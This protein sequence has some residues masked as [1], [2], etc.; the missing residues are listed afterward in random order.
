MTTLDLNFIRSQFPAFSEPSL[1]G[2][3]FFNNAGGSY[4]CKPVIDRLTQFYRET[5]VQP[6]GFSPASKI[7]G[8]KMD[9]SYTR[10]AAYLNVGEDEVLFGPSTSQ[11]T[12]VLA[13]AFREAWSPGDEI[14][15][16]NQDHEANSGVWRKLAGEGIVVR[17]WTID[18]ETGVLN[19]A[20][21][22]RMLNEKTRLLAFPHCSNVIAHENPVAEIAAK[23]HAAGALVVVDGVAY[24]PHGL[25]DIDALGADIYLFSTYKTYGPHQGVMV[26]R[27]P[28]LDQLANQGHYFNAENLRYKLLP[29]GPDHAQVAAAAGI[30]DY[31]DMAYDHHFKETADT[32]ERGRQLHNLF[33]EHEKKLLVKLLG[34]LKVRDGVR[35]VGPDDAE[36]RAP[37]VAVTFQDHVPAVVAR[38][39]VEHKI[40]AGAGHFYGVRPLIGMGIPL[41]TGVL[42]LSF[43]HY[44]TEAEI[45][46][47]ITALDSVL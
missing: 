25:P 9:E 19:L 33:Q 13:Q 30:A 21:L 5:K 46:Q 28:L 38:Q 18:K 4:A 6:H 31:F 32:P 11:N 24:A 15:V 7:A 10:L 37:T 23:A 26:I 22:D 39:L 12:Y 43:V 41:D 8:K 3:A 17:E 27:R 35:I 47:L 34:W 40:M 36:V 14:I 44:T 45:D 29:A 1:Q 2:W 20:D 42:R 16:T